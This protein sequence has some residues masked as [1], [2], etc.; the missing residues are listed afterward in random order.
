METVDIEII[1]DIEKNKFEVAGNAKD[2]K[3]L[4]TDFL[5]TQIGTGA[6][7]TPP[8]KQNKYTILINLD[9]SQDIFSVSNDCGNKGLRDGILMA[10]LKSA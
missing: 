6:D 7:S 10:F 3:E 8:N 5:R 9:P 2:P 4:V 1:F